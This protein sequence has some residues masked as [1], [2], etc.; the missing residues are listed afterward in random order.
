VRLR[1]AFV[2]LLL[3]AAAL[4]APRPARVP[5]FH[6]QVDRILRRH[7]DTCHRVGDIAPMALDDY[8]T[9]ADYAARIVAEVESGRMPP[10]R[11]SR[12]VGRFADER[13]LTARE[14]DVLRRWRDAGAPEGEPP[15]RPKPPVLAPEGWTLGDPDA[16]LD[17][18]ESFTVTAGGD[19]VYRCFPVPNPF[20]VDVRLSG[21]EVRPGERR[22]LHHVVLYVDPTGQS[23][24]L[25]AADP[26][27]GYECFGG[28][29]TPTPSVLGGWAPGNRPRRFPRGTAMSLGQGDVVVV[30]CHYHS[31]EE[32]LADRTTIGL[33]LSDEESPAPLF[34]L[35]VLNDEFTIPAGAAAHE[36]EALFDPVA[37]TG[38]LFA[39][40]AKAHA[41]MPH[42]HLLGRSIEVDLLLPDQTEQRLV[43]IRD[44]D[45]DWQDT[46]VFDKPVAMP[47]GT[48]VRVRSV[49]DNSAANPDN[50]NSPPQDVSY[51]ERTTDEMCLAFL[52]VTLGP[53]KAPRPPTSPRM[54]EQS[55]GSLLVL[56]KDLGRGGR[57]E[58]DGVAVPDS[59]PAGANRLRSAADWAALA[60][61]KPHVDVR[62]RRSDGRASLPT[63]WVR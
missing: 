52:E 33:F 11:P 21:I 30:Q 36:V 63:R 18:G 34:L 50:P 58:I 8:A 53:S 48:K 55:D 45:F 32:A 15:A 4:G 13:G 54:L 40:S 7:C 59:A 5:T 57:I 44:W 38:G 9:A 56:S 16:V 43:E 29:G 49:Y 39:P 27:P 3:A 60:A 28:P 19:D 1:A 37:L 35:P 62:V 47:S 61:G 6:G 42:M 10:W 23:L 25:D 12:D 20:G 41:V 14:L 26:A 2:A 17:Y 46:Y 24:G 31:E 22:V 51:G